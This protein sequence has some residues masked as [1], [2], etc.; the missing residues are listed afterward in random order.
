MDAHS[1]TASTVAAF[2]KGADADLNSMYT[3][4]S[5]QAFMLPSQRKSS[6]RCAVAEPQDSV[7]GFVRN[8]AQTES[9]GFEVDSFRTTYQVQTDSSD[10]LIS[11]VCQQ[12]E[13][14]STAFAKAWDHSPI[15]RNVGKVG[16]S[17]APL[18]PNRLHNLRKQNPVMGE[19]SGLGPSQWSTSSK[20]SW[21]H[22]GQVHQPGVRAAG[23]A[24]TDQ[25]GDVR[26]GWIGNQE[27]SEEWPIP[28]DGPMSAVNYYGAV[29]PHS[30]AAKPLRAKD[31]PQ[32]SQY[33]RHGR[34]AAGR[35][36]SL[37]RQ[38]NYS[39]STGD[40]FVAP[41]IVGKNIPAGVSVPTGYSLNSSKNGTVIPLEEQSKRKL[42]TTSEDA[43]PFHHHSDA[44]PSVDMAGSGA[45]AS[46]FAR[47][48]PRPPLSHPE[49]SQSEVPPA[50]Q[51]LRAAKEPCLYGGQVFKIGH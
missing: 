37:D 42:T 7:S 38:V 5:R 26:S 22:P 3:T 20:S 27:H 23:R 33:A 29:Q 30:A 35:I 31:V 21:Q 48:G 47:A 14:S 17:G 34:L 43:T 41:P 40:A 16:E 39:T 13:N 36:T 15:T 49:P 4:T 8:V 2:S 28:E 32:D 45:H 6:Q 19:N 50:I 1:A 46:A 24:S 25:V 9:P 44:P 10:K 51:R 11:R 12:E 18:S